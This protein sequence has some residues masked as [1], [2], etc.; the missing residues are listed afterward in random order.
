[1]TLLFNITMEQF[2]FSWENPLKVAIFHSIFDIT[3]KKHQFHPIQKLFDLVD[4]LNRLA[5]SRIV[6][7]DVVQKLA[8]GQPSIVISI[9]F[10]KQFTSDLTR[11]R[12]IWSGLVRFLT[13]LG[14]SYS[15]VMSK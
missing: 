3:Q 8:H 4:R 11:S 12:A 15:L 9:Q 7:E 1:M 13:P 5:R 2:Y 14:G 10:L 6:F